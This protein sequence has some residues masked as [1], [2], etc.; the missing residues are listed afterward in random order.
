MLSS[1]QTKYPRFINCLSVQQAPG[2][3]RCPCCPHMV[4]K[5]AESQ[6]K[7][8]CQRGDQL[9]FRINLP[10]YR[11]APA[12]Q[13]LVPGLASFTV[14]DMD[15]ELWGGSTSLEAKKY[16][17]APSVTQ[18]LPK[19]SAVS[20]PSQYHLSGYQRPAELCFLLVL[21]FEHILNLS[22][23]HGSFGDRAF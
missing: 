23:C 7:A 18:K 5:R 13:S 15:V 4:G 2:S 14:P 10:A 20:S 11:P 3:R 12:G 19:T 9:A 17:H 21:A 22:L 16:P 8:V 6:P 1:K